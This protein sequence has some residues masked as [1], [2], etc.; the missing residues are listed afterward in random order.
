M[1][2]LHPSEVTHAE[3]GLIDIDDALARVEELDQLQ[4]E[5]LPQHQVPL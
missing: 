4:G 5:L 3:P 2:P 1:R